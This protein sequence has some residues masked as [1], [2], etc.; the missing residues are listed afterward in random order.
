M[1]GDIFS[2]FLISVVLTFHGTE[3]GCQATCENICRFKRG[4]EGLN[5]CAG[6]QGGYG[7]N[8]TFAK[9]PVPVGGGDHDPVCREGTCDLRKASRY[10]QLFFFKYS[11]IMQVRAISK[12][13]HDVPK[14]R[15]FLEKWPYLPSKSF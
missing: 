10:V 3:A 6:I 8:S 11:Q 2:L 15:C 9:V 5:C 13:I 1:N 4:N 7:R 12:D 14:K